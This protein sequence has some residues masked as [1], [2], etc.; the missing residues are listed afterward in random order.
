MNE[1]RPPE[2]LLRHPL[3]IAGAAI[4]TA[5]A[6][7]FVVLLIAEL[8]GLFT[9]PYAGLVIFVAMP[10]I[11]TIGGALIP[12]G[13][14]LQRRWQKQHPDAPSDWPVW[15]FR[16]P[17]IRRFAAL[18][19][20]LA[21]VNGTVMLLAGYSSLHWM[22]SPGFC[23]QTCHTPM[24][25]QFTAWQS[26]PHARIACADCHIGEG[27]AGFVHAKLNGIHQLYAVA[28]NSFARPIPPGAVPPTGG[29]NAT[30]QTCH[31]PGRIPGDVIRVIRTYGDDEKNTES[32][33]VMLMH[34]GRASPGGR[35]IHWHADPGVKVEFTST[36][37]GRETI[38]YVRVT[39]ANGQFKEYFAADA[40]TQAVNQDQLRL[41]DCVD[42]HNMVGH[43]ISPTA[44]QA[45]D[46][47][48]AAS[49]AS[50]QLPFAR[51]ESV[52]LL[53]A[54]YSGDDEALQGIDRGLRSFYESH[55]GADQ[56]AVAKTVEIMQGVYRH[57]N[58]PTMKVTWGSYPDNTGHMTSN[59][60][61]RCHD[62]SHTA[63]DGSM[64]PA[65]CELCHTQKE[66]NP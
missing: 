20:V 1:P 8:A 19:V 64:I 9:N 27:A 37:N 39:N 29:F 40:G 24:H 43:R 16:D 32:T 50:R 61:F 58:F 26:G 56:A 28:T 36:G 12:V 53:Q 34:V 3:A 63:K 31:Q 42:C 48:L 15:D 5:A 52:R 44:E 66:S 65:D 7:V 14:W 55:T 11:A 4:A 59:G 33:T 47:A 49:P 38:P 51:R 17:R 25:V 6:V 46:E 13:M 54:K 22:D 21:A 30:C 18:L 60:C 2:A 23:G 62:G 10:A 41:M 35:A 57:N 45:V